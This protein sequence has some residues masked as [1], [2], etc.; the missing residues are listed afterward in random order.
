MKKTHWTVWVFGFIALA[1]F[2]YLLD[3]PEREAEE[4]HKLELINA[5]P[6]PPNDGKNYRGWNFETKEW[7]EDV[8]YNNN[9]N[10]NSNNN[11]S[12]SSHYLTDRELQE[13]REA[14]EY[15]TEGRYF[16]IPGKR[17]LTRKQEI[18]EAIDKYIEDNIEDILDEY[19]R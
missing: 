13:L 18:Q 5:N 9:N 14:M 12:S 10:Y 16:H 17:I 8:S 4:K 6:P 2:K 11:Q 19:G 7:I 15:D 1:A 3:A